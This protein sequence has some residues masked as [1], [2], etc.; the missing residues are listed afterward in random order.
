LILINLGEESF[1]KIDIVHQYLMSN[2]SLINGKIKLGEEWT[3][4]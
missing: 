3:K 1:K 2:S 4:A